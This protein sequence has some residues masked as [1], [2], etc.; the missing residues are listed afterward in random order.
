MRQRKRYLSATGWTALTVSLIF[1]IFVL[2][3]VRAPRAHADFVQ[4]D[5]G[6]YSADATNGDGFDL[7]GRIPR[8]VPLD[9]S[10]PIDTTTGWT[11][12]TLPACTKSAFDTAWSTVGQ[13]DAERNLLPDELS[14]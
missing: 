4:F 2:L 14:D 6:Y 3:F 5:E 8:T 10:L 11:I 1:V 13:R 9:A 12:T 7:T